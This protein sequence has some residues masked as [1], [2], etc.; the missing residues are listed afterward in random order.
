MK[1]QTLTAVLAAALLLSAATACG[2]EAQTPAETGSV[3]AEQAE[4]EAV[5]EAAPALYTD[6]IAPVDYNGAEF[7][8][9]TSNY[10][11][12][13]TNNTLINYAGEENGEVVNDTLFARDRYMEETFHVKLAYEVD[14]TG[15]T[16]TQLKLVSNSILAGDK[17]YHMI[18]LDHAEICK[19]LSIQGM[20]YPLNY[21]DGIRLNEG[22]WMKKLNDKCRIGESLYFASCAIS[23][24]YYSSVYLVMFNRDMARD[25]DLPDMYDMVESGKW[26]YD[27]MFSLAKMAVRDLNGD[28][29]MDASDQFGAMYGSQ[30]GYLLGAGLSLLENQNGK[31]V[32]ML[33]DTKTIDYLHNLCDCFQY[34]GVY[35]EN[36]SDVDYES[37]INNG[38]ALFFNPMTAD[39]TDY[40]DLPYDYGI[41]PFP[42]LSEEQDGYVGF[43]QP[44]VNVTPMI[45]I[46]VSGDELSMSGTLT[47]A[48]AA[49]GYDY[50]RPA[51]FDNVIC[52]KGTRDEQSA[53]IIDLIF[54]NVTLELASDL[55]LNALTGVFFDYLRDNLGKQDIVSSYAAQQS[56]IDAAISD[57]MNTYAKNEQE[58]LG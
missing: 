37:V 2:S 54:E 22:Y 4:T 43:S 51:V 42:K 27:Q 50:I 13:W 9:Y 5:T 39:L 57:I 32:C 25:L 15:S 14:E 40:R 3:Q 36:R 41:L 17:S 56:K 8:V 31:L 44:W 45:P 7:R 35:C 23:P 55:H 1:K 21:V 11:N 38:R 16:G 10:I 29:K 26:T 49:Y 18:L 52:L 33:N 53:R 6:S 47:D 19:S 30:E 58:I 48:M 24:R 34:E 28:G 12:G 46:T 20:L